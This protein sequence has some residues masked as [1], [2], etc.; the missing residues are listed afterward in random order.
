VRA[1]V[2][3][4]AVPPER[5]PTEL[6]AATVVMAMAGLLFQRANSLAEALA[7]AA[8]RGRYLAAFSVRSRC[9]A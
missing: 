9:L 6:L 5:R 3:A 8:V 7:P 4:L 2:A 1:C